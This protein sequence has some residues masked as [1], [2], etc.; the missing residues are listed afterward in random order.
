MLSC[1]ILGG[2]VLCCWT[3]YIVVK[4]LVFLAAARRVRR[5]THS[6]SLAFSWTRLGR[7]A[8]VCYCVLGNARYADENYLRYDLRLRI[9]RCFVLT[10]PFRALSFQFWPI[11]VFGRAENRLYLP[12]FISSVLGAG[13]IRYIGKA[14]V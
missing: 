6:L 7:T 3:C 8:G 5:L 12:T 13:D 11:Y 4:E 1:V 10:R 9:A 2:V 14:N